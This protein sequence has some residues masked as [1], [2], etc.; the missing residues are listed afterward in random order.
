M[1]YVTKSWTQ[2]RDF[3]FTTLFWRQVLVSWK[4]I[5]PQV[6]CGGLE[7]WGEVQEVM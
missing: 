6:E 1:D 5:F 7:E 4:T 3:R 2:L